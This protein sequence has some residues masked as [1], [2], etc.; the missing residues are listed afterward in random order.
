MYQSQGRLQQVSQYEDAEKGYKKCQT[1]ASY[2]SLDSSVI[3]L[4][5]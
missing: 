5:W 1:A 4:L 2:S 3:W